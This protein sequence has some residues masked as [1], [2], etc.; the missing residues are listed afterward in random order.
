MAI[1]GHAQDWCEHIKQDEHSKI[2]DALPICHE[3]TL[4]LVAFFVTALDGSYPSSSLLV[5]QWI[6]LRIAIFLTAKQA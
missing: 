3:G 2:V 4:A 5:N 6:G 1:T